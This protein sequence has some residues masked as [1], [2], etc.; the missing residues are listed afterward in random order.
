MLAE[1]FTSETR[2]QIF[3]LLFDGKAK[4]FYVRELERESG[5]SIR[6]IQKEV[7]HLADIDLI[8]SRRDGNRL[9]YKANLTHP[10]YPDLSSLVEKT[11]GVVG[12]I[13]IRLEDSQIES[14]FIFGSY[15]KGEEKAESDIDLIVIG[16][17]K[18]RALSKLLSGLQESVGREI[19]PHVYSPEEFSRRLNENDHFLT[20]VLKE[21]VKMVK[22]NL[23]EYR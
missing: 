1:L 9:Y 8:S 20:N 16:D 13:K 4:E 17:V 6:S 5:K 12:Q 3:R 10:L 23:D 7:K 18:M 14:A 11:V 21:K 15:A 2:A 22:G 19:N